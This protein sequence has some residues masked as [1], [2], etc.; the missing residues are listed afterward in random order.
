MDNVVGCRIVKRVSFINRA[1]LNYIEYYNNSLERRVNLFFCLIEITQ[2]ICTKIIS[3]SGVF[4]NTK[5]NYVSSFTLL[6]FIVLP[7][8]LGLEIDYVLN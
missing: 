3:M 8:R 7:T 2:L 5:M 6:V 1:F 4:S